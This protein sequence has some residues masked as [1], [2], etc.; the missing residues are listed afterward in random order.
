M[1]LCGS[2]PVGAEGTSAAADQHDSTPA[3]APAPASGAP[4]KQ[5]HYPKS[6][7]TTGADQQPLLGA[8]TAVQD[9]GLTI[10][11]VQDFVEQDSMLSDPRTSAHANGSSGAV[12]ANRL[13]KRPAPAQAPGHT[14]QASSVPADGS[15]FTGRSNGGSA[16]AN[17]TAVGAPQAAAAAAAAAAVAAATAT[18]TATAAAA[19]V[20][21]AAAIVSNG[22]Y[23]VAANG[24]VPAG[25]GPVA[26]WRPYPPAV[27]RCEA[28]AQTDASLLY[29]LFRDP[30]PTVPV[31]WRKGEG[32]GSGSFGQVG[33]GWDRNNPDVANKQGGWVTSSGKGMNIGSRG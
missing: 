19:G 4:A 16:P 31:R 22:A 10:T 14:R 28:V 25:S 23:G 30:G 13:F 33:R 18:A 21:T 12:I 15:L 6:T 3:P 26:A 24:L 11:P 32:I 2:R 27:P 9:G 7:V 20:A 1:G 17:G 8:E 29:P 5:S